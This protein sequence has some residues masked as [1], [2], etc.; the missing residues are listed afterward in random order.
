VSLAIV[1]NPFASCH[2]R[3]E[4][5]ATT[6]STRP[7]WPSPAND[8]SL[9]CADV[10]DRRVC[11]GTERSASGIVVPRPLPPVT[12]SPLGW[13]CT[14]TGASR[15][16]ADRAHEASPFRCQG[17]RCVAAHP[18]L[19]DDGEWQCAD[20]AGLV[21]CRGGGRPAGTPQGASDPGFSCGVRHG[22]RSEP[23]ERIC[24]DLSPDFPD[25]SPRGVR[26]HY[27]ASPGLER[28][29]ER[30]PDAHAVTDACD[31]R[32]PCVS[33]LD[34]VAPARSVALPSVGA[35]CVPRRPSPA[36]WL[37]GD[38]DKGVCR[39]GTCTENVP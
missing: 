19:P 27:E 6:A 11:W 34:C 12:L 38:C 8:L 37:D 36:C 17:S 30:I 10:G 9:A 2:A 3:P 26:C 39:F 32:H 5:N 20:F 25:G 4:S 7:T 33:G 29:C 22:A 23:D 31:A 24:V 35:T 18:R 21:V 14:G 16:C 15:A 13:R 28:V 1:V